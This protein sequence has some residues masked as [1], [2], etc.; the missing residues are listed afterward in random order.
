MKR[1]KYFTRTAFFDLLFN[2]LLV[3]VVLF[4]LAILQVN[5][6]EEKKQDGIK[7]DEKFLILVQWGDDLDDDV[8]TYVKD[9]KDHI[10]YFKRRE[11]GFM[12]LTRDDLG[13]RND[14]V[15]KENGEIVM[16]KKNEERVLF[17]G[18]VPG[19]YVVNV[20][21]YFKKSFSPVSV[22][23]TLFKLEGSDTEVISNTVLLKH[24]GDEKTAFRFTLDENGNVTNMNNA[25]MSIYEFEARR[26]GR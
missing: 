19:E 20:H 5:P 14:R 18:I 10:V 26:G 2:M 22:T 8:D 21:M 6:E 1:R 3:F 7:L 12:Y 4:I 15:R 11:D 25:P 9:P 23:I 17:R 13:Q 24:N 16:V